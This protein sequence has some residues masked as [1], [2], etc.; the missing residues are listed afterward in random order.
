MRCAAVYSNRNV[1]SWRLKSLYGCSQ[2]QK[3]AGGWQAVVL[4]L[5]GVRQVTRV[6]SSGRLL[7]AW[8][9]ARSWCWIVGTSSLARR[10]RRRRRRLRRQPRRRRPSPTAATETAAEAIRRRLNATTT[11]SATG[12]ITGTKKATRYRVTSSIT[13]SRSASTRRSR[14]VSTWCAKSTRKSSTV[15]LSCMLFLMPWLNAIRLRSDYDVSRAPAFHSTR[16]D[17][18]KKWTCQLTQ[19]LVVVM[20]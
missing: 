11:T 17:G 9:A 8:R 15:G 19:F 1:F 2:C 5:A 13:I 3:V 10:R 14:D 6:S 7:I 16:F 20:S 4:M 18:N 12:T